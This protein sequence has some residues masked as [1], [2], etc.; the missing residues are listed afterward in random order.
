VSLRC[1]SVHK[2]L[3]AAAVYSYFLHVLPVCLTFVRMAD[4][5]IVYVSV[6]RNVRL[7]T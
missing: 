5:G 4:S 2:R 3:L 1:V 6:L 7:V